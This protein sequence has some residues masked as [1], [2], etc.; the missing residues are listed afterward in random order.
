[1]YSVPVQVAMFADPLATWI[2]ML[3]P[4]GTLSQV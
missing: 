4:E 2:W 3:A 1:M